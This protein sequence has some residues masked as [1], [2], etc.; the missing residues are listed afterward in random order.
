[1]RCSLGWGHFSSGCILSISNVNFG[2][3]YPLNK[4]PEELEWMEVET[5]I[6][7][8]VDL[9]SGGGGLHSLCSLQI[10]G[11]DWTLPGD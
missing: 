4:L 5:Q 2:A 3:E 6:L 7:F 9:I 10:K 1:M 11:M 8:Q